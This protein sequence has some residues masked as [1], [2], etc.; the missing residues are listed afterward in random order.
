MATSV[1]TSFMIS[2]LIPLPFIQKPKRRKAAI[3]DLLEDVVGPGVRNVVDFRQR[4]WSK[5]PYNGGCFLKSLMPGTTK[6]FN[7]VL[8]ESVDR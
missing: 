6:Y 7:N 4:D 8:R 5:E 3:L 1:A 2:A